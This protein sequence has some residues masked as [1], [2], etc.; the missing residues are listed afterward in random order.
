MGGPGE[1]VGGS[2]E[3]LSF[4]EPVAF[5]EL[6]GF[7]E[8]GFGSPVG[9]GVPGASGEL[10]R[11]RGLGCGILVGELYGEGC[12]C[13]GVRLA[14]HS[15]HVMSLGGGGLRERE[16]ERLMVE[17]ALVDVAGAAWALLAWKRP[18]VLSCMSRKH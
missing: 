3:P 7:G 11:E 17:L 15:A 12:S 8:A 5:G 6:G 16:R 18:N 10:G 13:G 9:S 4:G 14:S 1:P 2:G